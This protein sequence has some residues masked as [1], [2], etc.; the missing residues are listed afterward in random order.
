MFEKSLF[1]FSCFFQDLVVSASTP[2]FASQAAAVV[3][4]DFLKKQEDE[5]KSD[6]GLL[7]LIQQLVKKHFER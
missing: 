1:F 7:E 3:L 2:S 5:T 6:R 4:V